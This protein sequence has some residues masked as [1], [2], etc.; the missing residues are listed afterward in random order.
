[1][2]E[3]FD[4]LFMSIE[5]P[6]KTQSEVAIQM[7]ENQLATLIEQVSGLNL[8]EEFAE[9]ASGG[10]SV[11][12]VEEEEEADEDDTETEPR[13][14]LVTP[15]ALAVFR[16]WLIRKSSCPVIFEWHDLGS[17]FWPRYIKRGRCNNAV[18][19]GGQDR[20]CSWP[21]GM[22]CVSGE[23]KTLHILRWH[24]RAARRKSKSGG[25]TSSSFHYGALASSGSRP[26][27]KCRWY[28]VPYPVTSGCKCACKNGN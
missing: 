24:C 10:E 28:K 11:N 22:H 13:S 17:Y 8:E 25:E 23:S 1:M 6:V 9:I 15:E 7:G 4:P 5:N 2:G 12:V 3:D 19:G 18:D 14:S 20:G 26:A 16:Q 27:H 21:K